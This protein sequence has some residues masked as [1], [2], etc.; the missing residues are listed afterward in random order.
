M[1]ILGLGN[2]GTIWGWAL[3]ARFGVGHSRDT[4]GLRIATPGTLWVGDSRDTLGLGTLGLRIKRARESERE[5]ERARESDRE[6][7]RAREQRERER[8]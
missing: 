6:R 1:S 4:L 5:R 3:Q 7:E 2:P 8:E